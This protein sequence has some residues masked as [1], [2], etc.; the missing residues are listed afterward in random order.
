MLAVGYF[1]CVAL[2]GWADGLVAEMIGN[3]TGILTGQLQVHASEYRP[4]R[5]VYET[6]GGRNGTDVRGLIDQ[7]AADP[8]VAAAAPRVYGGGLVS[9]G[10][11]TVAAVFLGVDPELE[12]DVSRFMNALTSGQHPTSGNNELLVGSEIAHT[13]GVG[14]GDEVVVVAPAI[15]GSLGNDLF[16]V[17]GV[18]ES[19]LAELDRSFALLPIDVLQTLMAIPPSRVHEVAAF[20][21]DPWRAPA[22]AERLDSLIRSRG[23]DVATESWTTLRPEMVEY[24]QLTQS[25]QWILLLIVF[26][27][28]IFGVANTMLMA[29]FERR[30]EFAVLKALGS[31]PGGIVRSVLSEAL[32][33]GAIGLVGGAAVTF[34]IMVWWHVAPPDLSWLFGDF[35]MLGALIRPVLRVEYPWAM[36]VGAAI[37]LFATAVLAALYPALRSAR[38][39]PADTLAGR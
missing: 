30:Y 38:V 26:G 37:A 8:D 21:R 36:I 33:L 23:L 12:P 4:D 5:S 18:Y 1:S 35:T 19:G 17:S 15:D 32:A 2:M 9:S 14:P 31:T 11:A 24:A 13:L 29:T 39:P 6:I 16:I 27:M 10:S 3:G 28:A 20:V 7:V 34:P 25:F 22:A